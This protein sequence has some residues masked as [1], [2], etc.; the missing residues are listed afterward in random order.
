MMYFINTEMNNIK[1]NAVLKY[2]FY[3]FLCFELYLY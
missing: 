1:N 3:I 2:S